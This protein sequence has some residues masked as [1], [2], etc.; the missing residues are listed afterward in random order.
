MTQLIIDGIRLPESLHDGYTAQKIQLSSDV[1]MI[2]GRMVRELRGEVWQI[3]YQYGY[4]DTDL[5]NKIIYTLNQGLR[6]PIV[7]SFI[8]PD[9]GSRMKTSKFF[10]TEFKRPKFM[11][12]DGQKPM[13]ADL[14]FTLREVKPNAI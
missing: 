3:T 10:V 6:A 11:W 7:C 13:W 4:V 1:E 9:S 8:T 2:T 5:K 12:S 14:S